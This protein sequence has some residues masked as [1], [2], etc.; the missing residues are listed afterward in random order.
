MDR[1]VSI[2][3]VA[4]WRNGEIMAAKAGGGGN[5]VA[6]RNIAENGGVMAKINE[7][8]CG[9]IKSYVAAGVMA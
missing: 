9:A 2:I 4:I 5:G 6:S 3:N 8:A 1:G 7:M